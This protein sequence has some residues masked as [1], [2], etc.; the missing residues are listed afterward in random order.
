MKEHLKQY[1]FRKGVEEEQII[2]LIVDEGQKMPADCL[3][4]LRELLNF[5]TNEYK[6]FQVVIF[7]QNEFADVLDRLPNLADRINL[8]YRLG[9]LNF[10]DTR[11]LIRHRIHLAGGSDALGTRLFSLPALWRIFRLSGGFPRKIVH[12]C[13]QCLLAMIIQNKT[14]VSRGMVGACARR[15]F[16]KPGGFRF[17]PAGIVLVLLAVLG[18]GTWR[19]SGGLQSPPS[20]AEITDEQEKAELLVGDKARAEMAAPPP[21]AETVEPP[22]TGSDLPAVTNETEASPLPPTAGD[23]GT[24]RQGAAAKQAMGQEQSPDEFPSVLGRVP[25]A[26]GDT[27]GGLVQKIYGAYTFRHHQAVLAA[28][29]ELTDPDSLIAGQTL[30]FPAIS[31][32]TET[33]P[34]TTWWVVISRETDLNAAITKLRKESSKGLPLR[35]L[36]VQ[37]PEE[38][39][40]FRVV[41]KACF[42]EEDMASHAKEQMGTLMPSISEVFCLKK[43]ETIVYSSII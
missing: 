38:D 17:L 11:A 42:K 32:D 29:P 15:T 9:P 34:D 36:A 5:E 25:V 30:V 7:A 31:A 21:A 13:H 41:L 24:D 35:L 14:T 19:Y 43:N 37:G 18:L 40:S 27:L 8:F 3:E 28:N 16:V 39:L 6:L 12:L 33:M 2:A 4:T 10:R 22:V 26:P 23:S 20:P 1:L